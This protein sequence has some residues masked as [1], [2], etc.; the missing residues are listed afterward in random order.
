MRKPVLGFALLGLYMFGVVQRPPSLAAER[1]EEKRILTREVTMGGAGIA[2]SPKM[3]AVFAGKLSSGDFFSGMEAREAATETEFI[4]N[5]QRVYS[6][7]SRL[8]V[9]IFTQMV[10]C[11]RN[12]PDRDSRS[13]EVLE[14]LVIRAE[15]K[16]GM[17]TRPVKKVAWTLRQPSQAE[18]MERPENRALE[19]LGIYADVRGIWVFELTIVDEQIPLSD[20][21]VVTI[22]S[23]KGNQITR[24]SAR[25]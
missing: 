12:R 16:K 5:S 18:W 15:W 25:L 11:R 1:Q 6:F 17:T 2:R 19:R 13:G 20:S 7:P 8:D 4:K 21:L 10:N 9:S 22:L 14:S 23:P 3:C 24:L